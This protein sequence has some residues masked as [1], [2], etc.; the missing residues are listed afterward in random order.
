M[1]RNTLMRLLLHHGER[2]LLVLLVLILGGI[3]CTRQYL[4]PEPPPPAPPPAEMPPPQAL[5]PWQ[6]QPPFFLTPVSVDQ[7]GD[8]FLTKFPMEKPKAPPPEPPPAPKPPPPEPIPEPPPPRKV[9][10]NFRGVR[11]ALTGRVYAMVELSDSET[12]GASLVLQEGDTLD[13]GPRV[14]SIS[15]RELKLQP[16]DGQGDPLLIPYGATKIFT[17]EPKP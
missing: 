15:D 11:T 8:P 2:K 10:V 5:L 17:L 13:F 7:T 9:A 14:L 4:L 6:E 1:T 16:A 3:F 12:G